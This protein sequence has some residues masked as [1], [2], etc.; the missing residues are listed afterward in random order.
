MQP[1][2]PAVE[3]F[4]SK[5][6]ESLAQ[7]ETLLMMRRE[8]E[9]AWTCDALTKLLYLRAEDCGAIFS[10]LVARGLVQRAALEPPQFQYRSQGPATDSLVDELAAAYQERRVAVITQIY[11]KPINK[12]QTFADAFRFRKEP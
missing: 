9:R 3:Q 4:I 12:V 11:S 5:H 7:L 10:D 1:L 2:S 8:P 6:I